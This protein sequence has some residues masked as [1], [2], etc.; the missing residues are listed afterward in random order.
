[1]KGLK[2]LQMSYF[3]RR[4]KIFQENGFIISKS[5]IISQQLSKT[6]I[7]R[8]E[9]QKMSLKSFPVLLEPPFSHHCEMNSPPLH[10]PFWA[11]GKAWWYCPQNWICYLV[12]NKPLIAHWQRH[13]LL[14]S[15]MCGVRGGFLQKNHIGRTLCSF[16]Y[17]QKFKVSNFPSTAHS[18]CLVSSFHLNKVILISAQAQG[19]AC[20]IQTLRH[21]FQCYN[22][23]SSSKGY[24][25]L[26]S[27]ARF[28][29]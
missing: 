4:I 8:D 25:V 26:E 1:M 17:T 22:T 21:D 12:C 9:Q 28:I 19:K 27:F 6:C 13:W 23:G 11:E 18:L 24:V 5:C 15:Y 20:V 14:F 2:H 10:E 16:I 3:P 29:Q 7:V